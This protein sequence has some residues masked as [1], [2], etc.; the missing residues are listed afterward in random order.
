[1]TVESYRICV[2]EDDTEAASALREGLALNHFEATVAHTG[3]DALTA[4]ASGG[5]DLILLDVGLPDMEGFTVCEQ[6]KANPATADIPVIFCTGKGADDDIMKGYNIGAVD[7]IT[8]PYNLPM[9]MV[10]CEAAM[11]N[12]AKRHTE[13]ALQGLSATANYTDPLTG[14]RSGQYLMERL[15]EE[16]EK[17]HRY[18]HPVSCVIVDVDEIAPLDSELGPV[19]LDDLLVEIGMA[20]RNHS[21]TYDIVSRY[22]GTMFAAVLPHAPEEDAR[23][24]AEKIVNEITSTIFA[25]PSYPTGVNVSVGIATCCNG[26]TSGAEFVFGEAMRSL[27]EAKSKNDDRLVA[28]SIPAS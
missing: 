23:R 19:S 21:R 5:I 18:D 25:D 4:C 2:V 11:R 13:R 27:L 16:V 20:L 3:T 8:K 6:L 14:L 28:R 15:E 10:R 17:A 24:Y 22:D 7:Y 26:H 12:H 1:M 9:V